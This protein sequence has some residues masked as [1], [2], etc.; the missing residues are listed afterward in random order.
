MHVHR[1]L[2]D[3]GCEMI[4]ILGGIRYIPS[5][6][7]GKVINN[8]CCTCRSYDD[9]MIVHIACTCNYLVLGMLDR[10]CLK[11]WAKYLMSIV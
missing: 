3:G 11:Y 5:N 6:A 7:L 8:E 10:K 1:Y 2:L 4:I 9:A